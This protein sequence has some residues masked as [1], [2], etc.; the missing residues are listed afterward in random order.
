MNPG[1][2]ESLVSILKQINVR[3][4]TRRKQEKKGMVGL[5]FHVAEKG[6]LPSVFYTSTLFLLCSR[7]KTAISV[8]SFLSFARI[9]RLLIPLECKKHRL[10]KK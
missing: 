4:N 1:P 3:N 5:V 7:V 8:I 2:E 10:R 6:H 9:S